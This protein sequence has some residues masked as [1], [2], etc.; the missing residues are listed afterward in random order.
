MADLY[1]RRNIP[2]D[3]LYEKPNMQKHNDTWTRTHELALIFIAL[4]YGSDQELSDVEL[5][6]ITKTLQGWRADLTQHDTYEIVLEAMAVYMEDDGVIE[7]TRTMHSLKEALSVDERRR[8]LEEV[9]RLAEADGIVMTSEQKLIS[10]IAEVW[11]VKDMVQNLLQQ[12][13]AVLEGGIEWSLA[14]DIG[15]LY[16]VVAHGSDNKLSTVELK[17]MVERLAEWLP[18]VEEPVVRD[19]L[20]EALKYYS[21]GLGEEEITRSVEAVLGL[22]V[23]QR[24]AVLNDI[25][26]IAEVDG[27]LSENEESMI[28]TLSNAWD[29]GV[30]L[31]GNTAAEG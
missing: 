29:V 28:S 17:A 10:M 24:L 12:T 20:R 11:E 6:T 31:N 27:Q 30:R 14:H 25:V 22:E 8:A 1:S 16:V 21:S 19:V 26:F 3:F 4:A 18:N 2:N 15:L 23:P 13:Q 9:V 7:V 5:R